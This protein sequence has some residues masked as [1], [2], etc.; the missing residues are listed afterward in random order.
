MA[1]TPPSSK[2]LKYTLLLS[3]SMYVLNNKV[4]TDKSSNNNKEADFK[5]KC[6]YIIK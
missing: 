3:L 6:F 4:K 2:P 1:I 5:H